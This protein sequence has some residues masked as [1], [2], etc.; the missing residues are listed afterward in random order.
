MQDTVEQDIEMLKHI[1]KVGGTYATL[2]H[3]IQ[4]Y[5]RSKEDIYEMYKYM[6]DS[7]NL[8]IVLYTGR[9]HTRKYHPSYFPPCQ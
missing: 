2:G 4:Y 6:C 1:E 7:T 9:L 3:P 5:P 8:G